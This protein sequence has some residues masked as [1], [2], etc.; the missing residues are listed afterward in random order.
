MSDSPANSPRPVALITVAFIFA[1]AAIG[2]AVVSYTYKAAP[3][4]PQ[5]SPAENLPK[6]LAWKATPATRKEA[7]VAL[8]EKQAKQAASYGW[9]DQKAGVVQLPIQRAMQLTA[10]QYGSK[11]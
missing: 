11:K 7:L 6:D 3:A 4:A 8:K 9:V 2:V 5:N 10:E 1:L